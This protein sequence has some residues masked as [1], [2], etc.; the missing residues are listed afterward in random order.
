MLPTIS[1]E[2][3]QSEIRVSR[4]SSANGPNGP[5]PYSLGPTGPHIVLDI[6]QVQEDEP[7]I[8]RGLHDASVTP[9]F[10]GCH[11]REMYDQHP[12][13]KVSICPFFI[14]NRQ[15]S[16][17]SREVQNSPNRIHDILRLAALTARSVPVVASTAIATTIVTSAPLGSSSTA[18]IPA[19]VSSGSVQVIAA[20][21]MAVWT[22][23]MDSAF[24]DYIKLMQQESNIMER[25][26]KIKSFLAFVMFVILLIAPG[27]LILEVLIDDMP[28]KVQFGLRL[29]IGLGA[30]VAGFILKNWKL[31]QNA[32]NDV[33]GS[34]I[35][36]RL[37][38]DAR[39]EMTKL[40]MYR[41]AADIYFT[42][43][44]DKRDQIKKGKLTFMLEVMM[45]SANQQIIDAP[46]TIQIPG[47]AKK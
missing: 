25:N 33:Q 13:D 39:F 3:K 42:E 29:S 36:G 2:T 45:S 41:R 22:P 47:I 27:V 14:P 18:S 19:V 8:Q 15:H 4:I 37:A 30:I 44:S 10:R 23:E 6:D 7:S 46:P 20:T 40:P 38:R 12:H 28:E 35:L 17:I 16:Q 31:T 32:L 26:S 5:S 43:L 24:Y 11:L 1:E 34:I 9:E 21:S